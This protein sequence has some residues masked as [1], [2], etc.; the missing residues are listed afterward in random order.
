LPKAES[1][2]EFTIR[3]IQAGALVIL[4]VVVFAGFIAI[5]NGMKPKTEVRTY[6]AKFT[7][8]IGLKTGA[9]V[10][11]GGMLSGRVSEILPDP[12]DQTQIVV[13]AEVSPT[14][15]VSAESIATIETL[16]LTSEKH[17]EIST[18]TRDAK[19][20]EDG[21]ELK[22]VTKSG[23][24]ID[25]PNVDG[26]VS[27]S[28]DLIS[29]LRDLLGVAVAKEV[30]SE[31]GA[32][33]AR[34]TLITQDVRDLLGIQ[35]AKQLE[36]EGKEQVANVTRIM[37]DLRKF[38]GVEEAQKQEAAG[39]G[40]LVE[41][42]QITQNVDQLFKKFEPQFEEILGKLPPMQESANKL[43]DELNSLLTDNRDSLDNTLK[44]VEDLVTGLRD[45]MQDL[46]D[47]LKKTLANTTTL[48]GQ[49]AELLDNNRPV[50]EDMIGDLGKTVNNLNVFLGMLKNNPESFLWGKPQQGRK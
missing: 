16:S 36:A 30:E 42:T 14:I 19:R 47:S 7:N 8:T 35:E 40:E 39:T 4:A 37:S 50:L 44:G 27:G 6:H 3:E 28:E 43:L 41:I 5:V 24:F 29:D 18:G 33:M 26:L 2:H 21:A 22:S 45:N 46:L 34:L 9:E 23:G 17:L 38:L 20:L 32:E 25:I 13:K 15:P 48:T 31:T 49:A 10:R 1:K 12:A 11:F